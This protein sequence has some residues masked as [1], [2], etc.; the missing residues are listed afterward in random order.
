MISKL[1]VLVL[2]GAAIADTKP[3]SVCKFELVRAVSAPAADKPAAE[4]TEGEKKT[5][6]G[7]KEGSAPNGILRRLLAEERRDS[8]QELRRNLAL[9]IDSPES[10]K[11]LDKLE[12]TLA[13]PDF[14]ALEAAEN[15][16]TVTELKTSKAKT[17][18][19]ET[20]LADNEATVPTEGQGTADSP[21]KP[22]E[23]TKTED[24]VAVAKENADAKVGEIKAEAAQKVDEVKEEAAKQTAAAQAEVQKEA[25]AATEAAKSA[26][27]EAFDVYEVNYDCVSEGAEKP[28]VER[29]GKITCSKDTLEFKVVYHANASDVETKLYQL[30]KEL[31]SSKTIALPEQKY[32]FA[33][34]TGD[35]EF[36]D[37]ENHCTLKVKF[38][39]V[40]A[41]L[42][43]SIFALLL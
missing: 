23:P 25:A 1:F 41:T 24:A 4:K 22:E 10:L 13:A 42:A 27:K 28:K 19:T 16:A 39:R 14:A 15:D 37:S 5:D 30:E 34:I 36:D 29:K 11:V 32:E 33:A 35:F 17:L 7:V 21:K 3:V 9:D 43:V 2:I 12:R 40:L 8:L 31:G 20:L 18:D 6:T 38:A 26:Y